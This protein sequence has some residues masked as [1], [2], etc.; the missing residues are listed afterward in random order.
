MN[1]FQN[2]GPLQ[3]WPD[4]KPGALVE[5]NKIPGSPD[6]V[7]GLFEEGKKYEGVLTPA[8][9]EIIRNQTN[10]S[11]TETNPFGRNILI[12]P[13]PD[14]GGCLVELQYFNE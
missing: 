10:N 8:K 9:V 13:Y 7:L 5:M 14:G 11:A 4:A 3:P 1:K 6:E 2:I 12:T